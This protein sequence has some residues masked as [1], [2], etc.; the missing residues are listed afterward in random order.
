[1]TKADRPIVA[2]TEYHTHTGPGDV[3]PICIVGGAP[4]RMKAMAEKYLSEFTCFENEHRGILTF[5]GLYKGVRVTLSTSGMGVP[6]VGIILPELIRSG[7]RIII[8]VGSCG[9]LIK[10]SNPGDAIIVNRAR[11][12]DGVSSQWVPWRKRFWHWLAGINSDQRV[13]DALLTAAAC[14]SMEEKA[15]IGTQGTTSDFNTG[16]ARPGL[17][18]EISWFLKLR[19][20]FSMKTGLI[21]CYSM[22]MAGLLAFCRY[23]AG[24]LPAG[25]IEAVFANRWTNEFEAKG[26]DFIARIALEAA[27]ILSRDRTLEP[28]LSGTFPTY[29]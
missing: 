22:E 23:K 2:N 12:W 14:V 15:F 6:Y 7:A 29:K 17:F 27:V 10:E 11:L 28:F 5:D 26:E 24:G 4:G 25:G 3:A 21:Q 20:W 8:R 1:M 19:H 13:T 9:S 16:Q 18:G